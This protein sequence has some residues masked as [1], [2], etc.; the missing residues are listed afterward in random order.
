MGRDRT[1]FGVNM[2][3]GRIKGY[4]M[5]DPRSRSPK[6]FSVKLVRGN[7]L[8]GQNQFADNAD[9]TVS[10]AATGLM[11]TKEDSGRALTWEGALAWAQQMNTADHLGYSDWKLPDAKELQSILDY[12]RSPQAT[13][14]AAIDP[15]FSISIIKDESGE[16]G[17]PF[18]GSSTTHRNANGRGS[19][20]VYLCFGEALGYMRFPGSGGAAFLDVHGAGAQ[21]SD[22]KV[23]DAGA[24]PQGHGPQGDVVRISHYVRLV[25]SVTKNPSPD[26]VT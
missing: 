11:W 20:G 24:Y 14:S 18:F 25:R 21:R 13:S 7:P 22:P 19:S 26:G 6:D 15:V 3:D 23:G 16:D 12:S 8:Y 2:A 1:V 4:P 10:D 5:V 17:Y 9:G